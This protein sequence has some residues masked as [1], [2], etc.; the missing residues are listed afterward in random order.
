ML[1]LTP[2]QKPQNYGWV[3]SVLLYR[4]CTEATSRLVLQISKRLY[5]YATFDALGEALQLSIGSSKIHSI[6]QSQAAMT[7]VAVTLIR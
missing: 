2:F 3:A 5:T 1:L 7:V 4:F 6:Q